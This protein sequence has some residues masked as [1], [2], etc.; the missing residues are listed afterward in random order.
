MI[1]GKCTGCSS[2]EGKSLTK[3]IEGK[4]EAAAAAPATTPVV[5]KT[6]DLS[7]GASGDASVAPASAEVKRERRKSLLSDAGI[8]R[9]SKAA[10]D[11]RRS[12]GGGSSEGATHTA[13]D[14]RSSVRSALGLA[15]E[16][17]EIVMTMRENPAAF[18][19]SVL[20]AADRKARY[21][22]MNMSFP[23]Q[24][25]TAMLKTKEGYAGVE[26]AMRAMSGMS[27]PLSPLLVVPDLSGLC[28]RAKKASNE[29]PSPLTS[30]TSLQGRASGSVKAI[31]WRGR[32]TDATDIVCTLLI[33][34]GNAAKSR[35][36]MLL[37]GNYS[38]MGIS[39]GSEAGTDYN[40]VLLLL[41]STYTEP[42]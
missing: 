16:I 27:E 12:V 32:F 4:P 13:A 15:Q 10:D 6:V 14:A 36:A 29:K 3:V 17:A 26:G 23:Y 8:A 2:T 11:I 25:A 22:D 33:D 5:K 34:D 1:G 31:H 19:S 21:A 24:G 38:F 28:A 37:S 9:I 7:G 20:G 35:R 41:V 42:A 40:Y 18:A 30:L 39:A